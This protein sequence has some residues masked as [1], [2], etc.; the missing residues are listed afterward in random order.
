MS[1]VVINIVLPF[2]IFLMMSQ[3]YCF[4]LIS[5]EDVGSSSMMNLD[6]PNKAIPS[7]SFRF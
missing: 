1:C 5:R 3:I 2:L 6:S 4:E 7:D